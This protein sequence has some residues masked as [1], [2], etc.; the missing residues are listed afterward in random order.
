MA[1]QRDDLLWQFA[2]AVAQ[3]GFEFLEAFVVGRFVHLAQ[4]F[5]ALARVLEEL[6]WQVGLQAQV[7]V[8]FNDV[9]KRPLVDLGGLDGRPQ[10]LAIHVISNRCDMT[11]L[12]GA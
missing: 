2:V 1:E 8:D 7:D 11:G 10:Q 3:F 4:Q 6:L 9:H 12:L 5:E